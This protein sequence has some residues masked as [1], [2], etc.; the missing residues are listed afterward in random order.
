MARCFAARQGSRSH[1]PL[2]WLAADVTKAVVPADQFLLGL[3]QIHVS[4]TT[5]GGD[6][7]QSFVCRSDVSARARS[8]HARVVGGIHSSN[9]WVAASRSIGSTE[10][11]LM[12]FH[13]DSFTWT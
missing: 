4:G 3:A 1:H 2:D 9:N 8:G 12:R 13:A 10:S 5:S 11:Q 6:G 7:T